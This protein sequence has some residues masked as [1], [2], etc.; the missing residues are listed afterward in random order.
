MERYEF[1][2][3]EITEL[4]NHVIDLFLKYEYEEGYDEPRARM[5]AVQKIVRTLAAEA[6]GL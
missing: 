4:L 5:E 1:D 2:L 3:D 6:D